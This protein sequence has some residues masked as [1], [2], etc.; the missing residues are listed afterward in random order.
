MSL[1]RYVSKSNDSEVVTC[2][3]AAVQGLA[4][5]RSEHVVLASR[6]ILLQKIHSAWMP[7]ALHGGTALFKKQAVSQQ[8][9]SQQAVSQQAVSQQAS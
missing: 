6:Y 7:R 2:H 1:R 5:F 9:V 3:N 8:A 4:D